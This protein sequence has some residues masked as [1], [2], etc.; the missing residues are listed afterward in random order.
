MKYVDQ[1]QLENKR[2]F[3]RVDFN[4]PIKDGNV[5][6]DTRIRMALDTIKYILSHNGKLILASHMGR[7]K[8]ERKK[9]LSFSQIVD[10]LSD[11]LE[12]KVKFVDDCIGEKVTKEVEKLQPGDVL[13]LENLRFHKEEEENDE[14]FGR[15]LASLADIYVNDAFGTVHRKHASIYGMVK[16]FEPK[17]R[18][19]GFII[20]KE[21]KYLRDDLK[22]PKRPFLLIL[23][24]AKVK[25]K[26][27]VIMNLINKVD[28]L[29][30]GGAM[31]YTFL[32]VKGVKTGESRVE[33]DSFKITREIL[34]KI[35]EKGINFEL[36][37]DH[38]VVKEIKEDAKS[39]VINSAN[40]PKDY[41]GLDIGPNT[42]KLFC[43]Y[44]EEAGTIV[45]N[46]PM[47]LFEMEK[48]ATGTME[49]AKCMARSSAVTIVG[50]GDSVSAINKAGVAHR[51]NHI[52]TGGGASLELL[53]GK[54]LPG[55]KILE[56]EE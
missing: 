4:V 53:T 40:I 9:E 2:V 36:P 11:L 56:E 38:V 31:A 24:G 14:E 28:N 47:G 39:M 22:N 32:A 48:F 55:I 13:L 26:I 30:I 16:F 7:P 21:L 12:Q 27:P 1:L 33:K 29:L 6:D 54:E 8:G 44:I 19:A 15:S 43:D 37:V 34:R 45:W 50:G 51:I 41:I 23:G 46:G 25:D 42:V 3:L 10:F 52:S 49:T 17:N 35:R 20:R 18:A 5:E